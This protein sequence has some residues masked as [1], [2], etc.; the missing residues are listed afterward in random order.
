M[1]TVIISIILIVIVAAIIRS[2]II[3]KKNGGGGCGCGCS[4]CAN[5]GICHKNE[6]SV[7]RC[8]VFLLILWE[9]YYIIILLG[10]EICVKNK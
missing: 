6:A 8:L 9:K 3:K 2:M 10:G 1:A 7:F 5:A 4:G